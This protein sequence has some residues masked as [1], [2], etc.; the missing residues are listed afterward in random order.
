MIR[1]PPRSTRTDTLFPYTTLFRS[2]RWGRHWSSK[3]TCLRDLR[4]RVS[5][6]FQDHEIFVRTHG[7]VRFLR[8]SALWQKRVA[9]IA[10]AILIAWAGITLAVFVNQLLTAGERA[11]VAQKA[12]AAADSEARTDQYHDR[13]AE[14]RSETRREGKARANKIK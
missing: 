10:G 7:H 6:L 11:E 12:A 3:T 2:T 5:A 1:R 13:V 9:L 14:I 8:V 4:Q